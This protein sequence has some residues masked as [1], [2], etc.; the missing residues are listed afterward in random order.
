MNDKNDKLV[1][2]AKDILRTHGYFVDNL[3]HVNDVHFLCEQNDIDKLTDEEAMQVFGVAND[4]FDGETGL[5]WPRIEKALYSFLN[6]KTA[7]AALADTD[8]AK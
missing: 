6:R 7:L 4:Q 2:V 1:E 5:S 8:A 3:W